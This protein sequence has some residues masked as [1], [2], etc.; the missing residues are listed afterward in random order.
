MQ[1]TAAWDSGCRN[2]SLCENPQAERAWRNRQPEPDL[3]PTTDRL[4]SPL[5]ILISP[6]ILLITPIEKAA[7]AAPTHL[8]FFAF[9]LAFLPFLALPSP[10]VSLIFSFSGLS[11]AADA[12]DELEVDM[13][14]PKS[15]EEE[16]R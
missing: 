7:A 13:R 10:G 15:I 2:P 6:L 12:S 5:S 11:E 9:F 14:R 3:N 1:H 4:F 8:S 16:R